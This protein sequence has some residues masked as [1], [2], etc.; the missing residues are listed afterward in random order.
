MFTSCKK[1]NVMNETKPSTWKTSNWVLTKTNVNLNGVICDEYTNVD[2]KQVVYE[3]TEQSTKLPFDKKGETD[4][5]GHVICKN[6]GDNCC[7]TVIDGEEVI[8]LK[9]GTSVH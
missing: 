4:Q 8:I 7:V 1:E 9:K 3:T 5:F 6:S 2:T